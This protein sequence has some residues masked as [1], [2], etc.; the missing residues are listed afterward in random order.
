MGCSAILRQGPRWSCGQCI[1]SRIT[2]ASVR[3]RLLPSL[4]TRDRTSAIVNGGSAFPDS[5]DEDGVEG[6][7]NAVEERRTHH[8][9]GGLP[10]MSEGAVVEVLGEVN[11]VVAVGHHACRPCWAVLAGE[12]VWTDPVALMLPV[13]D[14]QR[15]VRRRTRPQPRV[16][17]RRHGIQQRVVGI[18]V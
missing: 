13:Q 10:R 1:G 2:L 15:A 5:P 4:M 11:V 6:A 14:E 17:G 12:A 16:Y 9:Q 18:V 3:T 8:A 7:G